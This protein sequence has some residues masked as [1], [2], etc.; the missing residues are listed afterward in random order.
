MIHRASVGAG[1]LQRAVE[2]RA[3][4]TDERSAGEILLITGLL[5]HQHD[6]RLRRSFARDR[7]AGASPQAA[8]AAD[9]QSRGKLGEG[10]WRGGFGADGLGELAQ[11]LKAPGLPGG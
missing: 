4:R 5:A 2:Q 6:G 10:G 9:G 8:S 7:A 11:P 3:G 1:G